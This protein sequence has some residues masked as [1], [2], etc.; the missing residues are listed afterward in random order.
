MTAPAVTPRQQYVADGT[1]G[2]LVIP[3]PFYDDDDLLVYA[4][5]TLQ[6]RTTDYTLTGADEATG[7]E[8]TWVSGRQP[9][10]SVVVTIV[11]QQVSQRDSDLPTG[12]A[13]RAKVVNAD[14][15]YIISGLQDLLFNAGL[16]I[17]VSPVE[18]SGLEIPAAMTRA[19]KHLAFDGSGEIILTSD[20]PVSDIK[21]TDPPL[22]L[23]DATAAYALPA[24]VQSGLDEDNYAAWLVGGGNLV[25]G[26]EFTVTAD[27]ITLTTT[28]TTANGL[29]GQEL[30]VELVRPAINA[31]AIQ[32]GT[33]NTSALADLA[34]TSPKI[35]ITGQAYGDLISRD[36]SLDWV[37]LPAPTT[38]GKHFLG[39][40]V[41]GGGAVKTFAYRNQSL[42][43]A[44]DAPAINSTPTA[45]T[46]TLADNDTKMTITDGQ[47]VLTKT[48]TIDS[49]TATIVIFVSVVARCNAL[50]KIRVGLFRDGTT[51]ALREG[52]HKEDD[53]A[54]RN[55]ITIYATRQA[56]TIAF[57]YV[58]T[59][60]TTGA[61]TYSVRASCTD[62]SGSLHE[63][64]VGGGRKGGGNV[65]SSM[66][67]MQVG[68]KT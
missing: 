8:L 23:V 14:L 38:D 16:A 39:M 47:E 4:G 17:R 33:V 56:R 34:V 40:N 65:G 62:S 19:N 28:P 11:R 31:S 24:E 32:A 61:A 60:V 26:D 13:W 49:D 44:V 15:D 3:W 43:N 54:I 37:R 12:G 2:P 41:S 67:I 52:S 25:P 51:D 21:R 9:A 29:A 1:V 59:G 30:M 27:T 22:T 63:D 55:N 64:T 6:E 42:L 36:N 7:G 48:I 10:A 57:S 18:G 66:V 68:S 35:S 46:A 58:A 50:Q 5:E 53:A 20:V 45:I